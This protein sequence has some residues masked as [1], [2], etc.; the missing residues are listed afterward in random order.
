L[1]D[2]DKQNTWEEKLDV[3]ASA[4][5]VKETNTLTVSNGILLIT[6]IYDHIIAIQNY[7]ES[8]S[9]PRLKLPI[10]LLKPTLQ[11]ALIEEEDYGLRKVILFLK[12][13]NLNFY[14]NFNTRRLFSDY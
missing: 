14:F 7:E 4:S 5:F 1:L 3:I 6:T 10:T 11:L 2:L 13:D 8:S 12:S 9:L